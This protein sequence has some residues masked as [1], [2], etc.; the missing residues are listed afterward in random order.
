MSTKEALRQLRQLF[1]PPSTSA[2][3]PFHALSLPADAAAQIDSLLSQFAASFPLGGGG[4]HHRESEGEKE[5]ARWRE[6]LLEIWAVVEPL[7]GT[8]GEPVVIARVSAFLVLLE[9]LS[10][11]LGEDDDSALIS[12]KDVG[13]VW[14]GAVLRRTMLGTAPERTHRGAG[15][16]GRKGSKLPPGFDSSSMRPL[17]TSRVAL[18]AAAAMVVW[19][20]APS[21]NVPDHLADVITPFGQ[22]VVNEF[23]ERATSMLSGH[24][25]GYG[26]RNLEECIIGWGQN[27]PKVSSPS[28]FPS[29]ADHGDRRSFCTSRPPSSPRHA[30]ASPRC[31]CSSPTSLAIRARR[32][33]LSGRPFSTV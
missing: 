19:S 24:N 8:E 22:V 6:G 32:T 3:S 28:L 9:K 25:E 33:T 21:L 27:C 16:R 23:E 1:S 31:R 29:P 14:W 12:R 26:V 2:A 17:T 18:Q 7:P 4:G 15:E 30:V 20:M 11:G 10:A 13:T 5:R